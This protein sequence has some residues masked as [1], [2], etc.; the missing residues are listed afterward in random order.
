MGQ[1]K[2]IQ[3]GRHQLWDKVPREVE[4]RVMAGRGKRWWQQVPQR[5]A[6]EY[7]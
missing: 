4:E 7:S 6:G 2:G 3:M 5:W 1:R